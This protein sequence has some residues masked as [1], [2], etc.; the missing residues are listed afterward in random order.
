MP[1]ERPL[2][3]RLP[4][5]PE[6]RL[7]E[8]LNRQQWQQEDA[9]REIVRGRLEGSGPVTASQVAADSGLEQEAIEAAL[10]ALEVEGYVFRGQFTPDKANRQ[11]AETEWCERRLLQRIH[12][13]TIDA[14]RKAIKPVSMQNYL[15]FLFQ[16][17]QLQTEVEGSTPDR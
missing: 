15:Q 1:G 17:H 10:L 16:H 3:K 8:T 2:R 6:P 7:P 4:H 13:Y 9:I 5:L 12:R 14:H 11:P